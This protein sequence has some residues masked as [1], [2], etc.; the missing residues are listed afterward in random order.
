MKNL[1]LMIAVFAISV[2][3][4]LAQDD[5]DTDVQFWNE[6]QVVVPFGKKR[7][8][9]AA[10]ST[11]GR[12]GDNMSRANDARVGF[13][14]TRK[15]NKYL[16]LGG[17]YIYRYT[18]PAAGVDRYE[19]RYLGIASVNLPLNEKWTFVNRNMFQYENRHSR[20]DRRTIRSRVGLEREVTFAK[21]KFEPFGTIE[22]TLDA[23]AREV[24]RIRSQLGVSHK[25]NKTVSA[26]VFYLRQDELR[27]GSPQ[28]INALGTSLRFTVR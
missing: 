1:L 17:A 3:P 13:T 7:E 4:S 6:T 12:F 14:L 16:S 25:F 8:W 24:T 28:A 21:R 9:S 26:S 5:D 27:G 20:S 22:F 2:G 10:F 19:T 23:N 15:M 18:S 11:V